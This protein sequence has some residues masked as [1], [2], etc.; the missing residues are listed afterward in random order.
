MQSLEVGEN[1]AS[2]LLLRALSLDPASCADPG[3]PLNRLVESDLAHG[4]Q[5]GRRVGMRWRGV[6]LILGLA[7]T[8]G[9]GSGASKPN[10][11]RLFFLYSGRRP[12]YPHV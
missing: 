5:G 2:S 10:G 3:F 12:C 4:I 6:R 1:T 7:T 9:F 11:R 8:T